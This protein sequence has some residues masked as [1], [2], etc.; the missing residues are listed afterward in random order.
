MVGNL[1]RF[2]LLSLIRH[3]H[4]SQTIEKDKTPQREKWSYNGGLVPDK[5]H[6][7]ILFYFQLLDTDGLKLNSRPLLIGSF[8]SHM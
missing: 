1:F 4:Q 3:I 6:G 7:D 8:C 5:S 2:L